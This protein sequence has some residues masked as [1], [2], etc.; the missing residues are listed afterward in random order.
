MSTEETQLITRVLPLLVKIPATAY[1]LSC[2]VTEVYELVKQKKLDLVKPGPKM[3][4]ITSASIMRLAAER[5]EP[6]TNIPNLK[7]FKEMP[8]PVSGD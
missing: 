2:S 6:A 4:R 3:S 8:G 7:Q 1:E 5:A